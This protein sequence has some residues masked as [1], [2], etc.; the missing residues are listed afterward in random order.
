VEFGG[1]IDDLIH[2]QRDEVLEHD[3]HNRAASAIAAPTPT[4][5]IEF[6]KSAYCA[7]V[8]AQIA[9]TNP[10]VTLKAPPYSAMS[11]P[12]MNTLGSRSISSAIASRN[13]HE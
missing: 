4:P 10:N 2:R 13:A 11:S 12:R 1:V 6:S 9:R 3:V 7:R 5:Q 8:R